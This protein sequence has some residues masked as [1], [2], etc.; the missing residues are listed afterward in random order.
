MKI[1]LSWVE[2]KNVN[3]FDDFP[4]GVH[5]VN[6]KEEM[7]TFLKYKAKELG[8]PNVT[9]FLSR[10]PVWTYQIPPS[11]MVKKI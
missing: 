2:L 11:I 8:Y 4:H 9:S 6:S 10:E 5:V 3:T 7:K 1:L